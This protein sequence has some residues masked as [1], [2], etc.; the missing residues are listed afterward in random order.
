MRKIELRHLRYFVAV[1][2]AGSV[3]AGARAAG[4]VQPALS[5]QIRELEDAIGTPLLVRRATGVTLTAAG[6]SFLQD[7][8]GLLATLQD[9]RERALRSAAGQLGELRLGALPNCL[10]LPVVANVL[11]AF[12]DACPDVKLSIAPMLSAEQ[13]SA[14]VRGQLDGGIMAWRRDEAPHLSGVRLLSDRFV[15]AM[16]APPGGHFTAPR[17]LADV[18]NEPFVWFDAQRSAA[19]HRFLMAQCQLAGFSPRIAQV[20]SDIPTLIGLVA[21]GMGCAFVPESASPTCPHTVRLVALDELA[22]RFD[23]EFVFDGAAMPPSPAVA[24]FLEAVR[25]AAGEAN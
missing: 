24:R 7:A 18:A 21:A 15:L 16:P 6:A 22:S 23:I 20:G 10:P 13:A 17:T 25:D 3:M 4:I 11:K 12:R 9:S 2:Q 14:L 19:H 8:T 5:R 1:A